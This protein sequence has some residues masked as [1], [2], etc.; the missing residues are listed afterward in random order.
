[1]KI[2]RFVVSSDEVK[3]FRYWI[4]VDRE[5]EMNV[6]NVNVDDEDL[7]IA[8]RDTVNGYYKELEE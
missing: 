1:M 7:A 4:I 3:D 5:E 6:V 2:D 8:V